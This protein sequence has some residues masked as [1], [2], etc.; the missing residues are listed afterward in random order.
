MTRREYRTIKLATKGL[1]GGKLD[2]AAFD[3]NRLHGRSRDAVA[4]FKRSRSR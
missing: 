3:T 2:A 1:A 4:V